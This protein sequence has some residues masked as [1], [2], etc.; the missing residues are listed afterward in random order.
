MAVNLP[1]SRPPFRRLGFP[2]TVPAADISPTESLLII[3]PLSHLRH[4]AC[5]RRLLQ[6]S[7]LASQ[8]CDPGSSLAS[9]LVYTTAHARRLSNVSMPPLHESWWI[10]SSRSGN[11]VSRLR[12]CCWPILTPA[13]AWSFQPVLRKGGKEH[14]L[15]LDQVHPTRVPERGEEHQRWVGLKLCY[16]SASRSTKSDPDLSEGAS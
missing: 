4:H 5:Q 13:I 1:P 15:A 14:W 6:L 12:A 10:D 7:E 16:H 11:E 9:S 2:L 8:D 3:S